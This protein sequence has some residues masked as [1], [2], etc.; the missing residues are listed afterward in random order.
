MI[1]SG[2]TL[3]LPSPEDAAKALPICRK[4]TEGTPWENKT[5]IFH[6]LIH[7]DKNTS[8]SEEDFGLDWY[9]EKGCLFYEICFSLA[10]AYP[11]MKYTGQCSF[12]TTEGEPVTFYAEYPTDSVYIRFR[13]RESSPRIRALRRQWWKQVPENSGHWIMDFDDYRSTAPE[14]Q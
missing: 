1:I 3:H 2:Y 7:V 11:D 6:A 5:A 4:A 13:A 9:P 8:I 14:A 12:K 10:N